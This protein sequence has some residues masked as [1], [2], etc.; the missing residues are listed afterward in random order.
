MRR[1]PQCVRVEDK[2]WLLSYLIDVWVVD[3]GEEADLGEAP[4]VRQLHWRQVLA[5]RTVPAQGCRHTFG[6]DMGYSSGRNSSS[7][8]TPPVCGSSAVS[9]H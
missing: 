5:M 9:C 7:L 8:N 6:A 3:L 1:Q 4:E 2:V